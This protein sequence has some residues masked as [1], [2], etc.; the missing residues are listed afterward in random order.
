M[1][2]LQAGAGISLLYLTLYLHYGV[3]GLFLPL[4]L[5]DRGVSAEQVGAL[6]A[7]PL[8]L[9]LLLVA[10]ASALADRARRVR[11]ATLLCAVV[12]AVMVALLPLM[13]DYA[14]LIGFFVL[15][16]L[17]WDPLPVLAD[18]YAL[19]TTR[20]HK[21]DFG[22]VRVWGSIGVIGGSLIGGFVIRLTGNEGIPWLI[23]A[24]LLLPIA[25]LT[26]LPRDRALGA[27]D[28]A[29]KGGWREVLRDPVLLGTMMA[30]SL[31]MGSHGL[32]TSFGAIQFS[33]R[34]ISTEMIGTLNAIAMASEIMFLPLGSWLLGKRS[35]GLLIAVSGAVAALRWMA[36][37][38]NPPL[39]GLI[40]LQLLQG[41]SAMA[42]LLGM[43]LTIGVRVPAARLATAQGIGAVLLGAALAVVVLVSGW[44]WHHLGA[45]AY[46][47]MAAIALLGLVV[48]LA[49]L[50]RDTVAVA[51]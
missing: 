37:S 23:A 24:L 31:I 6:L 28:P 21:L 42:A 9:R 16:S 8:F 35:P 11:D 51:Q 41:P 2:R 14:L 17:V 46:L 34:G 45:L 33:E 5:V 4:W 49:G 18:A 40:G 1:T 47:P 32:I 36:M 27:V 48:V 44:L 29:A 30:T 39:W 15:F 13:H 26:M 38:L 20:A 10:P 7:I 50:R 12:S 19:I 3:L 22:Q 25:L 43:M